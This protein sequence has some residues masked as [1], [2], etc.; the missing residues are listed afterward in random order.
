VRQSAFL[1]H[2]GTSTHELSALARKSG[3]SFKLVGLIEEYRFSIKGLKHVYLPALK[4]YQAAV[5]LKIKPDR[6]LP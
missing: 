6:Y 4:K 5:K 2:K 1:P 3:G